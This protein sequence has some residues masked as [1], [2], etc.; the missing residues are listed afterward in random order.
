MVDDWEVLLMFDTVGVLILVALVAL[1]GFL[2]TRARKTKHGFLKWGGTIFAGLLTLIAIAL[3]VLALVGFYKLN[4]RHANPV[5]DVRVAGTPAQIAR[6]RQLAHLCAECHSPSG[7]LPLAGNDLSGAFGGLLLGT[8]YAPNLTPSGNIRDWSDGEVVRAI[9]ESVHLNGRSLLAMPS[10][11]FA[12]LSDEDVQSV[13]AYLRA[14][15]PTGGPTPDNQFN[16]LGAVFVNLVNIRTV[17]PPVGRVSA[18]QRGTPEYGGYMVDVLDCKGCH[19]LQLEGRVNRG[20]GPPGGPNLT[21]IVPQWT[22]EQFMTF[23]NTGK[24][25]DGSAVP[26]VAQPGGRTGPIMPWRTLRAAATDDELRDIYAYLHSL[27]P[28]EGP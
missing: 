21:K 17:Q 3:L 11:A 14:Q 13:V 23:F 6:G 12:K 20:I 15:P 16:V 25:P 5:A 7:Q 18:P 19:G 22:Q 26:V 10:R 9:R 2:T 1:F 8:F 4:E 28:V 24:L 27:P